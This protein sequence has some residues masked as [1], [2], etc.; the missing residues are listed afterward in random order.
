[1]IIFGRWSCTQTVVFVWLQLLKINLLQVGCFRDEGYFRTNLT[2]PDNVL[3][4]LALWYKYHIYMYKPMQPLGLDDY[5]RVSESSTPTLPIPPG[6]FSLSQKTV[7]VDWSLLGFL[8]IWHPLQSDSVAFSPWPKL[9]FKKK[10]KCALCLKKHG[11]FIATV[12]GSMW[13]LKGTGH[14][15]FLALI[16]GHFW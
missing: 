11:F 10:K 6:K 15:S 7:L 9:A 5:R 14:S 16:S 1:M 4:S 3:Q 8:S 12:L 13:G 2:S